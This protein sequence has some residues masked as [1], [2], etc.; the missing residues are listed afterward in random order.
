[1]LVS[2]YV[3]GICNSSIAGEEGEVAEDYAAYRS[4][5]NN[6]A[7]LCIDGKRRG[8][9]I[10]GPAEKFTTHLGKAAFEFGQLS[11]GC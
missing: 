7:M 6:N 1:M 3:E 11:R 10:Y 2:G 8:L 5:H 9:S 4:P